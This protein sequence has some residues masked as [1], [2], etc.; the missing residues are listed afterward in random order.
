MTPLLARRYTLDPATDLSVIL[1]SI[2]VLAGI[3]LIAVLL[4]FGVRWLLS[5]TRRK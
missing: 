3:G 5:R 4:W 2:I 1:L